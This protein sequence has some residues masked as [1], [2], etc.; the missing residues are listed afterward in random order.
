MDIRIK[1]ILQEE[2]ETVELKKQ[3]KVIIGLLPGCLQNV[4]TGKIPT[5]AKR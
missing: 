2:S 5:G 1:T 4:K 3:P